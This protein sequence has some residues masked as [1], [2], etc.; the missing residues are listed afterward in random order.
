MSETVSLNLKDNPAWKQLIEK[1]YKYNATLKV[2]ILEGATNKNGQSVAEYA[3]YNEFGTRKPPQNDEQKANYEARAVGI[4]ARPFM[5][6]TLHNKSAGW[7]QV[8]SDGVKFEFGQANIVE[9]ALKRVGLLAAADI[10]ATIEASDFDPNAL[11]T[12]MRKGS[13]KIPLKDTN[14]LFNAIDSEVTIDS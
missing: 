6:N 11:S 14:A 10:R 9:Q 3:F 7:A 12:I 13:S 4:P 5:R 2:G 8:F 1:A